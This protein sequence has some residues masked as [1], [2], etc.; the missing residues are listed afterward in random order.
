M[1]RVE[2]SVSSASTPLSAEIESV[3]LLAVPLLSGAAIGLS[4]APLTVSTMFWL[5]VPPL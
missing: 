3:E 1:L 2:L 5:T 4:L